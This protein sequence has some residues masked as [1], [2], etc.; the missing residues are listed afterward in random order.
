MKNC[1]SQLTWGYDSATY[2]YV[3]TYVRIVCIEIFENY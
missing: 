1:E 3:G 2:D